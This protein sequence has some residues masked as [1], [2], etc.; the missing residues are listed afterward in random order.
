MDA[1]HQQVDITNLAKT[2]DELLLDGVEIIEGKFFGQLRGWCQGRPFGCTPIE[3]LESGRVYGLAY[4]FAADTTETAW[5]PGD[6]RYDLLVRR[7]RQT[8]METGFA[9]VHEDMGSG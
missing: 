3:T 6:V 4:A 1:F 5:F 9:G 7:Y 2:V 8:A